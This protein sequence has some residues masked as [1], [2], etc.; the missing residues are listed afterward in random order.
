MSLIDAVSTQIPYGNP[1]GQIG[2][3]LAPLNER[4]IR[5]QK[6]GKICHIQSENPD[7]TTDPQWIFRVNMPLQIAS[8]APSYVNVQHPWLYT[9]LPQTCS[10]HTVIHNPEVKWHYFTRNQTEN[11]NTLHVLVICRIYRVKT[12]RNTLSNILSVKR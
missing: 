4:L 8:S 3:G 12:T 1:I 10:I 11:T 6:C 9:S 5:T 7:F 2:C